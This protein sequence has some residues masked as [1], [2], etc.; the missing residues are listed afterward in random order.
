MI[1]IKKKIKKFIFKKIWKKLKLCSNAYILWIKKG[2]S[3]KIIKLNNQFS[4]IHGIMEE[5]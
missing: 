3:I 1:K 5:T 4:D 2:H